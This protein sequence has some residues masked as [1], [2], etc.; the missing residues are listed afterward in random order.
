MV[1]RLEGEVRKTVTVLFCDVT[2]S[3][4]LGEQLDPESL[5]ALMSR[6]FEEMRAVLERHGGTVEKYIG[7]A[8]MAVF[9]IPAVHEDD[10]L[11]AVRAA[12]E[13]RDALASLNKELERDRGVTIASRIGVNTGD[14]VAGDAAARQSLVTGDAVNVAARLEQA[15]APG[16]ILIGAPTMS[17]VRDAVVAV[18]VESLTLKGKTH[19]VP[20]FRLVGVAHDGLGV[21]RRLDTPMVGREQE[22]DAL[23]NAF[24]RAIRD[25]S[26]VV[27]TIL[28]T[29]GVGKSRLTH[30]FL[31]GLPDAPVVVRGRCLSYGDGITYWPVVEMLTAVAGVVDADGPSEIRAKLE[32]LLRGANDAAIASERLAEFLGLAGATASPEETH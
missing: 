5:R 8:V 19:E 17:L 6:F 24:A 10:A 1:D 12:S 27:A 25:R 4:S 13:M 30:E 9:G 26:C 2:G 21:A 32:A 29:A 11:R 16:E 18:P 22:L 23:H 28:G 20:A 7:D 3:T 31:A 14:V 15:A